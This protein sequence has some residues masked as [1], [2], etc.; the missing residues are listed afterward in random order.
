MSDLAVSQLWTLTGL[1]LTLNLGVYSWL[2]CCFFLS[3]EIE[4]PWIHQRIRMLE[5]IAS[6]GLL[7]FSSA[8]SSNPTEVFLRLV[9]IEVVMP[10]RESRDR[11][12]FGV[13]MLKE[14]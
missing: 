4:Q 14:T 5:T 10:F 6:L 9:C 11:L 12:A 3:R 13:E 8:P 2:G 1:I 7:L